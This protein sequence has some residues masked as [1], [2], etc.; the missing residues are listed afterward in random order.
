[1]SKDLLIIPFAKEMSVNI[2]SK[3]SVPRIS[4]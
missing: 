1:M 2:V 3:G 4:R